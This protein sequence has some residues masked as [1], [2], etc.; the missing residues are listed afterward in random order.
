MTSTPDRRPDPGSPDALA[1]YKSAVGQLHQKLGLIASHNH[2]TCGHLSRAATALRSMA[3]ARRKE[4]H[5]G[6][7]PAPNGGS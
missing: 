4:P 3:A 2:Q 6:Q 7:G 5:P 1:G